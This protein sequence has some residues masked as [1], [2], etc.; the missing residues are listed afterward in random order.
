MKKFEKNRRHE[1]SFGIKKPRFA[2]DECN[3]KEC[4]KNWKKWV[5]NRVTDE[6][7]D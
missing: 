3:E 1:K 5:E 2:R 6:E 4:D 7:E